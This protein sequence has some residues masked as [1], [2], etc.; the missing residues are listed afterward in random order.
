MSSVTKQPGGTKPLHFTPDTTETDWTRV[1]REKQVVRRPTPKSEVLIMVPKM[2]AE[3]QQ[4]VEIHPDED[5]LDIVLQFPG[6]SI[7]GAFKP[8]IGN[9]GAGDTVFYTP[10]SFWKKGKER[11]ASLIIATWRERKIL[12]PQIARQINNPPLL[13]IQ[14]ISLASLADY[15]PELMGVHPDIASYN[16]AKMEILKKG[17]LVIVTYPQFH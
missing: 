11:Y 4:I 8:G 9:Y 13:P 14:Q 3:I 5:K 2:D 15:D 12:E 17:N 16:L 6:I 7:I 1:V 10:V